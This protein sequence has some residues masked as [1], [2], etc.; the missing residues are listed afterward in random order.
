MT[1]NKNMKII[2]ALFNPFARAYI[3]EHVWEENQFSYIDTKELELVSAA[4][5]DRRGECFDF[6]ETNSRDRDKK[7]YSFISC[8]YFIFL[9]LIWLRRRAAISPSATIQSRHELWAGKTCERHDLN[10]FR[11]R[12][13]LTQLAKVECSCCSWPLSAVFRMTLSLKS[14]HIEQ[15]ESSSSNLLVRITTARCIVGVCTARN[16]H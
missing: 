10:W 2:F 11:E 1:W 15:M 14:S 3:W 7:K 16:D 8:F 6:H 12:S 4:E 5:Q 9:R 13:K